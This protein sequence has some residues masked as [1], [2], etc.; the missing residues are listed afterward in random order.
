[1]VIGKEVLPVNERL[2]VK[3]KEDEKRIK[4]SIT[5]FLKQS[6]VSLSEIHQRGFKF[7]FSRPRR[8]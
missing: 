1:M 6:E 7:E 4:M 3:S 8:D 2:Y 5:D